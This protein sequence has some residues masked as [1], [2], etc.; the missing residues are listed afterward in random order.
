M[1]QPLDF[2]TR[3]SDEE[4]DRR[5]VV[6]RRGLPPVPSPEQDR[7]LRRKELD[8]AIDHRLG[9][10]FPAERREALWAVQERIEKRRLRLA[11]GYVVRRLFSRLLTRDADAMAAFAAGEYG[12]VLS[13]PELRRFLDLEEGAR[14]A[15]PVDTDRFKP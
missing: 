13:K 5:I 9:R 6:L 4:Y 1:P 14:P 7:E 12:K 8:L 3:L 11:L 15:L 2:G 10:G